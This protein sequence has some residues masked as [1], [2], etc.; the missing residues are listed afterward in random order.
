MNISIG[1]R[2]ELSGKTSSALLDPSAI[3]IMIQ[4]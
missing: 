1:R 3:V 2:F 4:V